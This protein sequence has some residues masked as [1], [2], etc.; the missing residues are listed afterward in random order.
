M[1]RPTL[2]FACLLLLSSPACTKP[3]GSRE[4][5]RAP[6]TLLAGGTLE[7]RPD[8]AS[9]LKAEP[10]RRSS[11][12][13]RVEGFGDVRFAPGASYAVR[14]PFAGYAERV[15]VQ[16]GET[17][18]AG[19]LLATLRSSEVARLRAELSRLGIELETEKDARE[20]LSRL[21]GENAASARELVES[22]SRI[23]ALEAQI[24]GLGQSLSASRTGS[25]GRDVV[26]L[27]ASHAGHVLERNLEPGER[28]QEASPEPAFTI[29]DSSQLVV[30]GSF[31]ERDAA[32]LKQG[33]RCSF[34]LPALG[35]A[36]FEAQ[37]TSIVQAIDKTTRALRVFCT[38]AQNDAHFRAEMMARVR[39]TVGGSNAVIVPRTAVLLRRDE[40]IVL[41]RKDPTHLERRTVTTGA[42]L[43]ADIQIASGVDAGEEIITG[44]AVLLDGEFD[45]LL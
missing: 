25:G 2:L 5:E 12:G 38:P 7:V 6:Y 1:T 28:I 36:E 4:L 41:V 16:V 40:R 27:R 17:V 35:E 23:R 45:Q 30:M 9:A 43:G 8:L 29:G 39:V 11:E 22:E 21:V 31:P 42:M 18:K 3:E 32:L 26:E 15:H 14:S 44:G 37:V 24:S 33:A 13:A 19:A 34:V 10:A 20:R